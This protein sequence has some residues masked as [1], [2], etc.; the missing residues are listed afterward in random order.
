MELIGT[1]MFLNINVKS[2]FPFYRG[3]IISK[4]QAARS[5][6]GGI[7]RGEG[8]MFLSSP[9]HRCDGSQL[10][11]HNLFWGRENISSGNAEIKARACAAVSSTRSHAN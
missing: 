1:T 6:A 11:V 3:N 2:H 9:N 4:I 8:K 10:K 7:R 5:P